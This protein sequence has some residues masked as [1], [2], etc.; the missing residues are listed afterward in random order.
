VIGTQIKNS[1]DMIE[2]RFISYSE[3]GVVGFSELILE[4]VLKF[5]FT[6]DKQR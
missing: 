4:I 2:L 1:G 5:G 3:Y 6:K